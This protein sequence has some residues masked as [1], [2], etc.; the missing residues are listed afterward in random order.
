MCGAAMCISGATS[1]IP[2]AMVGALGAVTG[3]FAGYNYRRLL[4]PAVPD[5]LLALIEDLVAVGG[6]FLIVS[7]L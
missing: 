3:A 7:R 6:G 4:S 5:L 2:G 1:P